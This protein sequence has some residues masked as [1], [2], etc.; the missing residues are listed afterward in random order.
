MYVYIHTYIH[1]ERE[2]EERRKE[3]REWK[4]IVQKERKER[5]IRG[6]KDKMG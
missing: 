3:K 1:R 4:E 6:E 5:E 2:R